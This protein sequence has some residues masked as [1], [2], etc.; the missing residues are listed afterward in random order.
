[1]E[2]YK[3]AEI[4][5]NFTLNNAEIFRVVPRKIPRSSALLRSKKHDSTQN[6]VKSS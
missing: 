1:M 4:T 3:A 5:Q 6:N 2:S